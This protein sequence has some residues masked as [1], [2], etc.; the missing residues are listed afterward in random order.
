MEDVREAREDLESLLEKLRKT[1]QISGIPETQLNVSRGRRLKS[2]HFVT[3][4]DWLHEFSCSDELAEFN[5]AFALRPPEVWIMYEAM[6]TEGLRE[7]EILQAA[8]KAL[9]KR[10]RAKRPRIFSPDKLCQKFEPEAVVGLHQT[11]RISGDVYEV[12][13]DDGTISSIG[14]VY[15]G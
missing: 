13:N 10:W 2:Q 1:L 12:V 15:N 7:Q 3:A 8:A 5:K 4:Y 11:L 9:Q 6:G 14:K